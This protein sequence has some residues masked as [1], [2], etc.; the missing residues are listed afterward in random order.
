MEI[1]EKEIEQAIV[2]DLSL[3]RL[4]P[5]G[6]LRIVERQRSLVTTDGFIDLLLE[7]GKSYYIVELKRNY[8]KNKTVV[9]DQLLRYRESLMKEFNLPVDH[10]ICVLAS[11]DGFSDEV[12]EICKFNQVVTKHLDEDNI[13]SVLAN[14]TR[15]YTNNENL[16]TIAKIIAYRRRDWSSQNDPQ[17]I[18]QGN[19]SIVN[20]TTQGIHDEFAMEK[21]AK[22][23]KN[24]SRNAPIQS[25]QVSNSAGF[26]YSL[27]TF[28]K[29]WFWLFYTVLDKRANASLFVHAREILE[30]SKLFLPQDILDF[31][32]KYGE[33]YAIEKITTLLEENGFPL[34]RD[35]TLGKFGPA[36]AITH[37]A[38]LISKYDYD[39]T[40][41][42]EH[43]VN[44]STSPDL[45]KQSILDELS[46]IHGVGPRMVA[47]F[48]R[49][50]VIKG[51]W[52]FNLNDDIFLEK[53]RFNV[54]FA[55]P[56]RFRLINKESE[57]NEKL[58]EF[59]DKFLDGNKGILSH[60]LW[61][62]RKKY[63]G[64]VKYCNKC[65]MAGFCSYYLK[66]NTV[67][68]FVEGQ[69]SILSWIPD[70]LD[71]E[72]NVMNDDV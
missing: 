70:S 2:W 35:Y 59:T 25:H 18:K 66:S 69:E 64:K 57:Y 14:K 16:E 44:S 7:D 38:K 21:M 41:L 47:Q 19:L 30:K 65:P 53:G 5:Y 33:Q 62:V 22:I 1:P 10:F 39:F 67:K 36:T 72:F 55:G 61:Y 3:L 50:M 37:A 11:P 54:Y 68:L 15:Q 46:Q 48:V 32:T 12:K 52:K 40:K 43:H 29:C 6:K 13:L 58:K 49:G 23:F 51:N 34:L 63:C 71:E 9:T 20:W 60:S 4:K 31:A 42:Y 28:E 17:E 45:A 27:N 56:A 8:I 26:D 24:I